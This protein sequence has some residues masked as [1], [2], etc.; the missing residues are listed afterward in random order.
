MST[1][2][3]SIIRNALTDFLVTQHF[4]DDLIDN[5]SKQLCLLC[6]LLDAHNK[7]INLVSDS[8]FN[9]VLHRHILDSLAPLNFIDL[10]KNDLIF[11]IGSGAG[12]PGIPLAI[13]RND[14]SVVSIESISK[15]ASFQTL[16]SSSLN[17][18][19][20]NV[21]NDRAEI[22]S[23]TENR[24]SADKVTVRAVS[25]LSTILEYAIPLLKVG[26]FALIYKGNNSDDELSNADDALLNLKCKITDI[27]KYRIN[28]EMPMRTLV[29]ARKTDLTPSKYPR[30]AGIPAKR[31][32]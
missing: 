2:R 23:R 1:D 20:F 12:F 32:L 7:N 17:L 13:L 28:P 5:V 6:D 10:K 21:I 11:D 30:R 29:I 16:L 26:G 25:S 4:E 19:N 15:K 14:I 24:E 9:E 18:S 8:S 3:I 31:P 22:V 27:H